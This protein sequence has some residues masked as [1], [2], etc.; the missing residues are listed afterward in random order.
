MSDNRTKVE[1][2]LKSDTPEVGIAIAIIVFTAYYYCVKK[3]MYGLSHFFQ[4]VNNRLSFVTTKLHI[5]G[6][7]CLWDDC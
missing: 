4:E 7:F 5:R 6:V 3:N 1:Q 2:L